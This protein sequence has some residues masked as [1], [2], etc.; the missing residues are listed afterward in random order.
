MLAAPAAFAVADVVLAGFVRVV[1][2]PRIFPTPTPL[3]LALDFATRLRGAANAVVLT[4]G[5]RHWPIFADLCRAV[6]AKGN[7]VAGAIIAA[8]AIEH[9]AE[10]ISNDRDFARFPG[11]RWQTP[12]GSG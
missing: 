7:L 6:E 3:G 4:P 9:G 2:N 10:V 1:T 5:A 11:L 12:A 8:L